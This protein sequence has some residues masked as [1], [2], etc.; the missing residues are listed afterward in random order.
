VIICFGTC[1][2]NPEKWRKHCIP[3]VQHNMDEP[4][5]WLS[6]ASVGHV[7]G[8]YQQILEA[9]RAMPDVDALVFLHDDLEIQDPKFATKIREALTRYDVVGLVGTTKLTSMR[10][11]EHGPSTW[12]GYAVDGRNGRTVVQGM[13]NVD[14]SF[15]DYVESVDGMLFALNRRAIDSRIGFSPGVY[16]GIH[17][18]VEELCMQARRQAGLK[19]GVTRIDAFHHTQG[20]YAGGEAAFDEAD[21]A[22]RYV[23]WS[24]R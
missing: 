21:K 11:W 22:F 19:I 7:P 6:Y 9:A 13:R 14:G 23:W 2:G 16:R 5:R 15:D 20:G 17:G 24:E 4:Y 12:R 10:W 1:V 3:G 18:Y 8:T